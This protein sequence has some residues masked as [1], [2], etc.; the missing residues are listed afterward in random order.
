SPIYLM[1]LSYRGFAAN[2]RRS[3]IW[4]LRYFDGFGISKKQVAFQSI[5]G[6]FKIKPIVLNKIISITRF[7]IDYLGNFYPIKH[8]HRSTFN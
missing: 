1:R 6:D 8:E 3:V 7:Q 2:H 4:C 5:N